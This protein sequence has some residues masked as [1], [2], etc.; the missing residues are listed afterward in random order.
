MPKKRSNDKPLYNPDDEKPPK[1]W[2]YV[3]KPRLPSPGP[4]DK[5]KK[6]APSQES[7]VDKFDLSSFQSVDIDNHPVTNQ[8]DE[9]KST[10]E[11]AVF[12][13]LFNNPSSR[14]CRTL[15]LSESPGIE[16]IYSFLVII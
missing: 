7:D 16:G 10:D 11:E 6:S 5:E 13:N 15:A 12:E 3:K 4:S 14:Q 8:P 9:R 1:K 2:Q